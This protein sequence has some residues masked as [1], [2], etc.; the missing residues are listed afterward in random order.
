VKVNY[1]CREISNMNA[2]GQIVRRKG[3]T[4]GFMENGIKLNLIQ[5]SEEFNDFAYLKTLT[6]EINSSEM[7][8]TIIEGFEFAYYLKGY[9]SL[10][11][12]LVDICD[13]RI[14]VS[15]IDPKNRSNPIF[16]KAR[17]FLKLIRNGIRL[18]ILSR[19]CHGFIYISTRDSLSDR[20]FLR[21]LLKVT[22]LPNGIQQA[23]TQGIA[24]D[25]EGDFLVTGNWTYAPN[26]EML[27]RSIDILSDENIRNGRSLR[28]VGPNLDVS[29][30]E[31]QTWIKYVGW[32]ENPSEIYR[33]I[34]CLLAP[35]QYGG[36]V[37]NKVL[38]AI[39]HGIPVFGTK[40]AF[41]SIPPELL[42]GSFFIDELSD[43]TKTLPF[44]M[45]EIRIRLETSYKCTAKY[46]WKNEVG[47]F[48]KEIN[49]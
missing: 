41:A 9:I 16:R 44:K 40:E 13:S 30:I 37:K 46:S 32:V 43:F 25:P 11:N 3:I 45:E 1:I 21:T 27:S 38:D 2:T 20:R 12:C 5:L 8:I 18:R 6:N 35:L 24:F 22:I 47:N 26:L 14:L 15:A 10:R 33:K 49:P 28:I 4:K 17:R 23:T 31:S 19:Q 36:G 7:S 39:A 48:L 34:F 29:K 42:A